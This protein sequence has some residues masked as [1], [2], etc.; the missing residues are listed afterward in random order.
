M[1]GKNKEKR[2]KRGEGRA[3]GER[4]RNVH[5]KERRQERGQSSKEEKRP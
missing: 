1:R 4:K 3:G 5:G 2:E